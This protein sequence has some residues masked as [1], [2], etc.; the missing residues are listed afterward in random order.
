MEYL[1]E[2]NQK[3]TQWWT[4]ALISIFPILSLALF[5]LGEANIY[6]VL[7]CM[8]LP[9]LFYSIKLRIK[10]NQKGIHYQFF[11]FHLKSRMIKMEN[12]Q[13]F[14]AIK[15]SPMKDYGG[16]GIKYSISQKSWAYNVSGNMG[17][18]I[19]LKKEGDILFGSQKY[20]E[21]EEALKKLHNNN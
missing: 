1:F 7:V 3:F 13:A 19:T 17:V 2:E 15:Y 18:K 12:I 8:T 5:L 14:N 10:I 21:F 4:W 9:L 11:P 16:W 20:K 6:Y